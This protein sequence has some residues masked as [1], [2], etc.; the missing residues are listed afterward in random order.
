MSVPHHGSFKAFPQAVAAWQERL[1]A[2]LSQSIRASDQTM[3]HLEEEILHKTR[4]LE[5]AV[6]E[7]HL[8]LDMKPL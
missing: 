8:C 2:G 5:R 6:L 4:D 7:E 1:Q 3:G